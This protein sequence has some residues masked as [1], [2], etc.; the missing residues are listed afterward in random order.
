[1]D[2]TSGVNGDVSSAQGR[3]SCQ[4]PCPEQQ[5]VQGLRAAGSATPSLCTGLLSKL[6]VT[7]GVTLNNDGNT[8]HRVPSTKKCKVLTHIPEAPKPPQEKGAELQL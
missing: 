4:G 3:G 8:G 5:A 7:P 6:T 2:K 1:M